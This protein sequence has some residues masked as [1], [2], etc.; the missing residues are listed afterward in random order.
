MNIESR[1]IKYLKDAGFEAYANVP[2]KRPES[3][4]TVERTGGGFD[5]VIIDHP[6]IAIQAWGKKRLDASELAYAV[7]ETL[8]EMVKESGICKVSINTI[9]NY[10]DP[11]SGAAR[12]QLVVDFVVT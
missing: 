11:E 3:F 9:Y 5:N 1:I 2:A 7:R 4:V 12:Y 6:T 8:Q 10:P